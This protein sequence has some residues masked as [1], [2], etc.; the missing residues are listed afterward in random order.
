MLRSLLRLQQSDEA[1]VSPIRQI[2]VQGQQM[3]TGR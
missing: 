2:P 3:S 1:E